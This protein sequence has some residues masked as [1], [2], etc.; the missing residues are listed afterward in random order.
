[1]SILTFASRQTAVGLYPHAIFRPGPTCGSWMSIGA[2]LAAS[3]SRELI[4]T[5]CGPQ[6]ARLWR[7]TRSLCRIYFERTRMDQPMNSASSCRRR[8][9]RFPSTGRGMGIPQSMVK[10]EI[11]WLFRSIRMETLRVNPLLTS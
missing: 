4:R 6:I 8:L 3:L 11:C 7:L 1:M 9:A 2:L 10:R 5:P